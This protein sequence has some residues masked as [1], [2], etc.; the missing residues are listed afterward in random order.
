MYNQLT[1]AIQSHVKRLPASAANTAYCL[2]LAA[3]EHLAPEVVGPLGAAIINRQP[4]TPLP[5]HITEAL[6]AIVVCRT[7]AAAHLPD[8]DEIEANAWATIEEAEPATREGCECAIGWFVE[9]GD[10]L[11]PF[12]AAARH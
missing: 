1:S 7:P 5:E 10:V 11:R 6:A 4:I 2:F 3:R 8:R 12:G 9:L